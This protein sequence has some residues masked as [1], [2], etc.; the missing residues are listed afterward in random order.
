MT[1]YNVFAYDH[2]AF[3]VLMGGTEQGAKEAT[4]YSERKQEC[5]ESFGNLMGVESVKAKIGALRAK[6][7]G[8]KYEQKILTNMQYQYELK[9]LWD[10]SEN[11]CQEVGGSNTRVVS[12]KVLAQTLVDSRHYIE[13]K[14][15]LEELVTFGRQVH[16]PEYSETKEMES[17]LTRWKQQ[18]VG[19]VEEDRL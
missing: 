17:V 14:G 12:G 13:A 8:D 3:Y 9:R 4:R 2:L 11:S 15:L 1:D 18:I 7:F 5:Y 6:Y 10:A 16:G 19:L